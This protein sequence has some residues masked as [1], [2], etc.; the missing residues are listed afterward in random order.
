MK[1]DTRTPSTLLPL[2]RLLLGVLGLAAAATL[3]WF[4]GPLLALGSKAPLAGERE[5][6]LAIGVLLA[7]VALH[8]VWRSLRSARNNRRLMDSMVAAQAKAPTRRAGEQS[9][10]REMDTA[11]LPGPGEH[12]VAVLGER[13]ERA[14]GQLKHRRVGGRHPLLAAL[15]G[16][17]FVYELPWY[18]IIGAP[19]AGKTTALVNSGLEFPLAAQFGKKALRGIAGTRNCDWWFTNDAVLIDTAGRYTTQDSHRAADRTAWL[20]FLDLLSQYRPGRPING[21]LLTISVSDLL[22]ANDTQRASH[23][24]ELR[25]RIDELQQRL[26]IRFPIYVMVTKCDLMAGFME[27]FADFDKDER[28]QV[29]GITFPYDTELTS[30]DP[31]ARLASDFAAL[32]KRLNQCLIDRLHAQHDRERRPAIYAFPQQWSVLRETLQGFLQT[33]FGETR[34]AAADAVPFLRGVYFTSATQ[35]G[36]PVDRAIGGLARAMGLT[37]RLV[38]P[39]RPSGKSF[40]VTHLLRDVVFAEAGLAGTNLRWQRRRTALG[41]AAMAATLCL[42]GGAAALTWV[43]Y[44]HNRAQIA[45]LSGEV[46]TLG[47]NVTAAVKSAPTDLLAL[48]PT[49]HSLQVLQR[50]AAPAAKAQAAGALQRVSAA[51]GFDQGSMLSAAAHDGYERLLKDAFVPRVAAQ[52]E[53]R[54]RAG[55]ADNVAR[56][57]EDLKA[58]LMLFGGRNFDGPAL[59]AFV[60]ADWDSTL[61]PNTSAADR[62]ALR[63]HLDQLLAR[64]EVGAPSQA[65]PQVVEQARKLVAGVPLAQRAYSRLKQLDP[66]PQATSFSVESA[67]GANAHRVFQRASGK[68]L[69][70]GVPGLYTRAVLQQSLRARTQEVLRQLGAEQAWVLGAPAAATGNDTTA[71]AARVGEEVERLYRADY[72]RLWSEFVADLRLASTTE[73]GAT[74]EAAQ[75]LGHADS[76]LVAVLRG[77]VQEV[78]IGTPV[79]PAQALGASGTSTGSSASAQLI[80]PAFEPL[81]A[82][83]AGQPAP[84]DETLALLGRLSNHL[85]AVDDAVKRKTVLPTNPVT[86]DLAAAAVHAPEPVRSM[87]TE[88]AHASAGQAFGAMR[89]PLSRQL[90]SD[91]SAC[92]NAIGGHYPMVRTGREEMSREAFAQTF[93]SGGV[94][95][96]FFQRYLL[97]YLDTSIRP[98]AYRKADG[99]RADS[100]DALLQFQRAQA[101]REAYFRDGGRNLG[102]QLDFRLLELDA[103]AAAFSLDI[104]GQVLRF[105]RPSG[106]RRGGDTTTGVQSAR[107]PGPGAGRVHVQMTPQGGSAGPGYVF[108]GPWA[109]LRLFDRVRLEPGPTPDRVIASFDVEGRKARFEVRSSSPQNPLLRQ[110]LEQFQCPKRL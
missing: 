110:E 44:E 62:E 56:L 42:V 64:G 103:E 49:L 39:A 70:S 40:F 46:A 107:W 22:G 60:L 66:G 15:A 51:M 78:S 86:R 105:A 65:Q 67:G 94:V 98:W 8:A 9:A 20:G 50:D 90:A 32:E 13:F 17:P 92:S 57:Y 63:R 52:L 87:L 21:V 27:F 76:P 97:P 33:V 41:W 72:T 71:Q 102:L 100:S 12:E 88:L 75:V 28:A 16:R 30:D 24:R 34:E 45:A 68:P 48:L 36:T 108:E 35:E 73:L 77:V 4:V 26:D 37:G 99:A 31:L 83:V 38:A 18:V 3:V 81:R 2:A 54:L 29:W 93:A 96:G 25:A 7:L 91:M 6:W 10:G 89:E 80:D 53:T 84:V 59:R 47:R 5:R 109:L 104:D 55:S 82:Y 58:Y 1:Q 43:G 74:A 61:P 85:N 101:I 95:D 11:V 79:D 23:A 19:G 69:S 14:V 106:G